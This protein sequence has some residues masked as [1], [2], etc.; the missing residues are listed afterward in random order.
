MR[1]FSLSKVVCI[2]FMFC[3]ATA[4]SLPAQTLTTLHSFQRTTDGSDPSAGLVQATDGN[5]YG[6]T[7]SGGAYN[8]GTVF[9]MTPGGT[10]TTLYSFCAQSS[11]PDGSASN[12]AALVQG[13]DGNFYG[14][15]SGNGFNSRGTVFKITP[16]G[17]LTTL[18]SFQGSPNDG[19]TPAGLV[20]ATDGN[21]YGTTSH[22]GTDGYGTIFKITPAGTLT[23]L[24]SFLCFPCTDGDQPDS[25]LVQGT[26]GNFYGTTTDG[27]ASGI[28]GTV[29]KIT[30]SGTLTTLYSFNYTDGYKPFQ[31]PLVQGTDGNFYGTTEGGGTQ[32]L[33][34]VFKITPS[35]TLT[36]LFSFGS[37]RG[38]ADGVNPYAG[39]VQATDGNFYGTTRYGG[40]GSCTDDL[41][42]VFKITSSGAYTVLHSFCSQTNCADGYSPDAG[43]VQATDGNFYGTT[44]SGGA[45]DDGTVFSLSLGQTS[46]NLTV[47]TNGSGM[48]TSTDGF[49]NCPGTCNHSYPPNTP[50]TLNATPAQG[51]TFTG[52]SG[53]CSGTGSCNLT[54]TQDLSVTAT[55][56]Q[57]PVYYTLSVS[58]SGNGTVTSTDGFINCPGTCSYTYSSGT[59]VTLDATPG[60][61]WVFG[62]WNG[63][64]AGTGPC[65]LTMTQSLS[66]GAMF[67][68]ALQFVATAPCRLLDT[69]PQYGGAGP[70]Q[71][72]T[73]ATFNL[74]QLAQAAKAVPICPRPRL[75][76]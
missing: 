25:A 29:F 45:Y 48:V 59:R 57:T 30:P 44:Q 32:G 64:C 27:G 31:A 9:K 28:Y 74:P 13:T 53:A 54:M 23:T 14:T 2:V 60:Q 39:L 35:G 33:G 15:T 16:S 69:R 66:V 34:T 21:F 63:A 19:D 26:D 4:I 70:I 62:G 55:F 18:H 41:G 56:S 46:Y 38:C 61:G 12:G 3:A 24:Y 10:V 7:R 17:T 52:W 37:Q 43:L 6:T 58:P 8:Q 76:R 51:W 75:I 22:G 50:V 49:I 5:F 65:T 71:G 20:Q 47:S 36:T 11:C 73:T 1:E 42:T 67:S 72:G 68:Q 40:R